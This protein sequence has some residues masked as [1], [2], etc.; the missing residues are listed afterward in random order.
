MKEIQQK[1]LKDLFNELTY[2]KNIAFEKLYSK[3]QNLVYRIAF[4]I[5]KNKIDSEDI[6]QTVFTKI[7]EMEKEKLPTNNE[8]SWLYSLTKNQ[9]ISLLRK[10][11][12]NI[13]LENIYEL[14][15]N[16]NEINKTIDQDNYNKLISKLNNKEKEILSLKI[17]SGLTFNEISK[18]LNEPI[19]TIKWRYYK[20][21]HTLRILL[22]NLG[23]FIV[24]FV[25]G[26]K[27]LFSKER[28]S[29][30]EG[31]IENGNAQGS[32]I[33]E[34]QRTD[35]IYQDSKK[36]SNDIIENLEENTINQE[37]LINNNTK[38][39]DTNYFGIGILGISAV[40]LIFTIIFLIFSLKY[41]LNRSKKTS[42]Q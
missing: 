7:Y 28:N 37:I 3:Y 5:L 15:D 1:E 12:D 33:N 27:S 40:F 23:M 16:N 11:N 2:N 26:V 19:G 21:I 42:K 8:A 14:R 29:K 4:S 13:D 22:G 35:V 36:E 34:E 39:N 10:R 17:I 6:V 25:I 20:S 30:T 32:E 41:Q 9:A 31:N 38:E 18:I 24:T